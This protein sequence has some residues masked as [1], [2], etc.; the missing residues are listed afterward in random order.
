MRPLSR[1]RVMARREAH[2]REGGVNQRWYR[3]STPS[4]QTDRGRFL[5]E[6]ES[7][8]IQG[9]M[10]MEREVCLRCG[11]EISTA[12]GIARNWNSMPWRTFLTRWYV[13]SAT[14]DIRETRSD[15][16]SA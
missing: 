9:G 15:A 3:V 14:H 1:S 2:S 10:T 16:P 7:R 6:L 12:A 8:M 13:L 4:V 11:G 5:I